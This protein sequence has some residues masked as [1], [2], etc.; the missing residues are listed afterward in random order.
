MNDSVIVR[1]PV[2]GNKLYLGVKGFPRG[3]LVGDSPVVALVLSSSQ[4]E[5]LIGHF[6]VDP[7]SAHVL[8]EYIRQ[9][10]ELASV[11]LE[12]ENQA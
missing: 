6:E 9:Q 12:E 2:S 1:D 11:A 3:G 7:T 8:S 5:N 10:A 4:G